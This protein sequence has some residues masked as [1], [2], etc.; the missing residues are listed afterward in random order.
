MKTHL[1][2]KEFE[3]KYWYMSELKALAKSLEIPFDTKTRKDQLETLIIQFLKTGEVNKKNT[4]RSKSRNKD[5]LQTDSY[6]ENFNNTKETWGFINTE[7]DKRVP[8]LKPK[9]GAKYAL[10]RWIET[11]L[12]NGEKIT[13][14]DV[15]LEYIRL[16]KTEGK[17]PQIPS[18][19]FNNFV[20]D[21]LENEKNATREAAL[22]AW[23]ELK[24]MNAK[25]DY[26]TWK[27]NKNT[28][29]E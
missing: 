15:I 10:N 20:S 28:N 2:T 4:Y 12:S 24:A 8:G 26:I 9:S 25:K 29:D 11:K 23:A 6:V 1:T 7:M 14:N 22:K 16:N 3:N 27:M 13:Y 19:K 17:L 5:L 21:Y 18:C